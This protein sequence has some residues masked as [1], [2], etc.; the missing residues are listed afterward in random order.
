MTTIAEPTKADEQHLQKRA[1]SMVEN[2]KEEFS[3]V[4]L[5]TLFDEARRQ[6]RSLAHER[7]RMIEAETGQLQIVI[8]KGPRQKK[9]DRVAEEETVVAYLMTLTQDASHQSL[10]VIAADTKLGARTLPTLERLR[11]KKLVVSLGRGPG[12]RWGVGK[13]PET[14]K[15]KRAKAI[16]PAAPSEEASAPS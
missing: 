9:T 16:E 5:A 2:L 1:T 14:K 8:G 7:L 10:Q 6:V 15:K 11:K 12:A 4:D 3:L 13:P